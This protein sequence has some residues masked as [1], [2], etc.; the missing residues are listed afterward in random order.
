MSLAARRSGA[1]AGGSSRSSA[2]ATRP[3]WVGVGADQSAMVADRPDGQQSLIRMSATAQ[4]HVNAYLEYERIVGDADGGVL[5]GEEEYE[6][7]KANA[8]AHR[9]NR[10]YVSWRCLKSGIDCRMVGPSSPCFCGHRFREHATDNQKPNRIHCRQPG[11]PCNE[12]SYIPVR[13]TQDVKCTCKHSYDVHN[14]TGKRKCKQGGCACAGFASSLSCSCR[15]PYGAHATVFETRAERQAAGRP[16]DNLAGGGAGYEALGGITSFSSLVDG[17]DRLELG[18]GSRDQQGYLEGDGQA[19][20]AAAPPQRQ[21]L[22]AED[23]FAMYD[24]KYKK[25]GSGGGGGGAARSTAVARRSAGSDQS[26]QPHH[27][28]VAPASS[29]GGGSAMDLFLTPHSL[30]S[31]SATS[32]SASRSSIGAGSSSRAR[33]AASGSSSAAAGYGAGAAGARRF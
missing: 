8:I 13:G 29:A 12:Y 10:T 17:I 18:P 33:I 19:A 6:K 25:G 32:A 24:A 30:S 15:E 9:A 3:E 20:A 31:A 26:L 5:M 16:V 7:F 23:E 4:D 22:K 14:V 2:I 11:C 27:S 28:S 1:A 21:K